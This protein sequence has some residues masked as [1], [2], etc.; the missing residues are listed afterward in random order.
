M[1]RGKYSEVFEG[2]NLKNQQKCII[3][4]LKPVKKKKVISLLCTHEKLPVA[5]KNHF[6]YQGMVPRLTFV[7]NSADKERNQDPSELGGRP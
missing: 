7:A 5:P 1:G 6:V 4:I 2:I 3:K